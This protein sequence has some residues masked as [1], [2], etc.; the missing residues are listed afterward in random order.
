MP[1]PTLSDVARSYRLF[2]GRQVESGVVA[3]QHVA[4]TDSLWSLV[5]R[6][7]AS[8]EARRRRIGEAAEAIAGMDDRAAA[9]PACTPRQLAQMLE[10]VEADWARRGFG[11]C[12]DRLLRDEPRYDPK[13]L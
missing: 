11:A 3:S 13:S 7:W 10:T 8:P 5:E 12:H 6:V 9:S 4:T 1:P 2:L